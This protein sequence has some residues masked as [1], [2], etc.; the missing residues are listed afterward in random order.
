MSQTAKRKTY[1]NELE[2][3]RA[4]GIIAVI[5]IHATSAAVVSYEQS[6]LFLFF[7]ALNILSKFAVPIFIMISG[8]TLFYNYYDKPIDINTIKVFYMKRLTK[9]MLPFLIFSLIYYAIVIYYRHGFYDIG[10]F[11]SYFLTW[12][13]VNKLIIGKTYTHLYFIFIIIQ[14]YLLFPLMWYVLRKW[15]SAV[16]WMFAVGLVIQW[17]Y[18]LNAKEMGIKYV[19]SGFPAYSLYF[20][21]GAYIGINYTSLLKYR[22]QKLQGYA[23]ILINGSM[24]IIWLVSG[25]ISVNLF[26]QE[27]QGNMLDTN[28]WLI[29]CIKEIYITASCLLLMQLSLWIKASHYEFLK[30]MLIHLGIASF[31]IYLLH[32][33]FLK[34][35]RMMGVEAGSSI[36]AAW[37]VGGFLLAL[38]GSWG[39]VTLAGKVKGHWVLFGPISHRRK[40][41]QLK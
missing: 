37:M 1:L 26:I 29:E 41:K 4:F 20:C 24:F 11:L 31:G 22:E 7:A 30:R 21:I 28:L 36:Y 32:P 13:F 9:L 40:E 18:V 16:K 23:G 15:A 39:I 8:L 25:T 5:M 19:M 38:L 17:L 10:Q 12:E 35:Y 27:A 33:L 6:N 3:L 2:M 34:Y 14:F